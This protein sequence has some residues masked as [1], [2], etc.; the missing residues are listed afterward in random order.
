MQHGFEIV[1][2]PLRWDYWDWCKI[3]ATL[4]N[5]PAPSIKAYPPQ[6]VIAEKFQA[7]V[8]LEMN[9]SR[10]KDFYD[11]WIL[12]RDCSFEGKTLAQAL[13]AT[14]KRRNTLLP[15]TP[16]IALK[17]EFSEDPA[18]Q[19]EWQNFLNKNKLDE[20]SKSLSE[21]T[22]FLQDFLMPPCL[23]VAQGKLFNKAWSISRGWKQ[24]EQEQ[25]VDI[26]NLATVILAKR[27]LESINKDTY[28]TEEYYFSRH[29]ETVTI[30]ALDG[31]GEIARFQDGV[32]TGNLSAT[33]I[34]QVRELEK[35]ISIEE[36]QPQQQPNLD[37]GWELGD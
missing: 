17:P 35:N 30:T 16:P 14:F 25:Q 6:T 11:L 18:K 27:L 37:E 8:M 13:Q 29:G 26:T 34:Y 12:G 1:L 22:K 2:K 9:N 15:T 33:D 32:F 10:M 4:L 20:N 28:E 19:Y 24:N 7:M 23:A 36:E 21:V 3:W 31:R 5:F